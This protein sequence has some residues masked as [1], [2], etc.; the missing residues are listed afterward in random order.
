MLSMIDVHQLECS[1]VADGKKC[2]RFWRQMLIAVTRWS[3]EGAVSQSQPHRI[4]PESWRS[5]E[6]GLQFH[7]PYKGSRAGGT[8][9]NCSIRAPYCWLCV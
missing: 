9:A 6:R 3:D 8:P 5:P 7:H 1:P 4:A 2:C